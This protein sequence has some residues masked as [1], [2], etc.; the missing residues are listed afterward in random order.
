MV[1]EDFRFDL[2]EFLAEDFR[3][4]R[5]RISDLPELFAVGR[6]INSDLPELI[7][8]DFRF[9]RESN[10]DLPELVAEDFRF[11]RERISDLPEFLAPISELPGERRLRVDVWYF[12]RLPYADLTNDLVQS[13]TA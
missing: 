5:E 13:K 4:G 12:D 7:A 11:G 2:P 10:Y 9:G 6:E 1:A 8:E 3:F